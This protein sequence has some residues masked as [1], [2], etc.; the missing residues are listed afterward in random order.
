[1]PKLFV[2]IGKSATGKDTIYKELLKDDRLNLKRI[3]IYT[4]RPIRDGEKDGVE[5]YFVTRKKLE[6]LKSQDKIIEIRKYN[7]VHGLWNYFTVND[8]QIDLDKSNSLII[9]TLESY[10][11][12]RNYFGKENVYPIYIEVDDGVRLQRALDREKNQKNPK[13]LEMCRRFLADEKDFNEEYLNRLKILKRYKNHNLK[14]CRSQIVEDI[15][16][17]SKVQ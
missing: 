2:L 17:E 14:E 6:E 8:G 13:Y 16:K 10:E 9:G 4:T 7:T 15:I 11:Q 1:M 12:I 3:V 5:Y